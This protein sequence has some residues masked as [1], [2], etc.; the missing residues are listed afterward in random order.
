MS[1]AI[2]GTFSIIVHVD[3]A[4]QAVSEIDTQPGTQLTY[5]SESGEITFPFSGVLHSYYP[6]GAVDRG[7]P[8]LLVVTGSSGPFG[9]LVP[10][11]SGRVVL[12][13]TVAD[14]QDGFPLTRFTSVISTSGNFTGQAERICAALA[15]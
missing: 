6:E 15:G 2:E 13:G 10:L 11:G 8:A 14:V 5:R 9:T 7:A 1:V 3:G 12:D 4:G